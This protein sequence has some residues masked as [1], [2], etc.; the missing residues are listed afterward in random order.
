VLDGVDVD[1]HDVPVPADCGDHLDLVPADIS[2]R[3]GDRKIRT[4][5]L[6]R[7]NGAG[8]GRLAR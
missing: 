1:G 8:F 4:A 7:V 2:L 5:P 6:T 3:V